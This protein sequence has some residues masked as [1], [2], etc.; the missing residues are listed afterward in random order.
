MKLTKHKRATSVSMNI[1]PMIDIVFLLIIFFITV[2]QLSEAK[3]EPVELPQIKGAEE[4]KPSTITINIDQNGEVKVMGETRTVP[5]LLNLVAN[6]LEAKGNQPSLLT[7]VIRQDKRGSCETINQVMVQ[8][9]DFGINQVR[10]GVRE[11]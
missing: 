8:L 7:I 11:P 1:T 10:L 9:K 5:E 2:S 3:D 4:Q 6:E